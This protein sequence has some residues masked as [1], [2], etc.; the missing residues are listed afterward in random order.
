MTNYITNILC[1]NGIPRKVYGRFT[2]LHEHKAGGRS[3]S[4]G[5]L[6]RITVPGFH[7]INRH[8][9]HRQQTIGKESG[10]L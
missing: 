1:K 10:F 4:F 5:L 9:A 2:F 7:T 8:T 3:R 6:V